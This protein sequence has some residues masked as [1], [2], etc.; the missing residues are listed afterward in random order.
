MMKQKTAI[1]IIIVVFFLPSS[2]VSAGTVLSSYKYAWSNNVGYINFENVVVTDS[3]L[4]GYAWSANYGWIKFNPAQGGVLNDGAGNLSGSA[5]GANLGWIDFSNVSIHGS[6]GKFSGTATG[7]LVGTITFDCPNYC[8]V[9]TDW[10]QT[11][12]PPV[13]P[14]GGGGVGN[15]VETISIPL[16]TSIKNSP[17]IILPEQSGV[18]IKD[19]PVGEVV[20]E[21]PAGAVPHKVMFTITAESLSQANSRMSENIVNTVDSLFY[22][23]IAKDEKGQELHSFINPITIVLPIPPGSVGVQNLAVYWLN[24]VNQQWVLIPEIVFEKNKV[25][26]RINHLTK[27]AIFAIKKPTSSF[28][29][30]STSAIVKQT[31]TTDQYT[32]TK[33]EDYND[34]KKAPQ[35]LVEKVS[36]T[37]LLSLILLTMI[38]LFLFFRKKGTTY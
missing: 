16:Q 10:Q 26:F 34:F 17:L 9:R 28:S 38:V 36:W 21:I 32:S 4:S 7:E 13:S 25:S 5:W 29:V 12:T 19:T 14:G 37:L 11:E 2:F 30:A 6:T 22:E 20:I 15:S 1:L 23:I 3:A 35:L 31:E 33:V 18:L 24:E 27:F 8:D